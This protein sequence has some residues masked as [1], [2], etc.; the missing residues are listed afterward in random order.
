MSEPA[1]PAEL[2]DCTPDDRLLGEDMAALPEAEQRP[3]PASS[4]HGG[5]LLVASGELLTG[6]SLLAGVALLAI[7]LVVAIASGLGAL[8]AGALALGAVLVATHWGWV[9][10]AEAAAQGLARGRLRHLHEERRDWLEAVRPYTRYSVTTSALEDGSIR[11]ERFVH[12]PVRVSA[13]T[14]S[15]ERR[16]ELAEVLSPD[17]GAEVT[18]R[19]ESLRHQ[20]ALDTARERRRFEVAA[21]AYETALLA[22]DNEQQRLLA[23]RAAAEALSERINEKLREPPLGE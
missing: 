20:A 11:I 18:E 15:F 19:A 13:G 3:V 6:V 14:F 1:N 22:G 17:A 4:G 8:S 7:G 16:P 21:D 23:R 5:R 9:H 12:Q 10:A 2:I